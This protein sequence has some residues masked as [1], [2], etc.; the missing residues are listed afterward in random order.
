MVALGSVVFV[1][2]GSRCSQCSRRVRAVYVLYYVGV[3]LIVLFTV[4]AARMASFAVASV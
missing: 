2:V 3:A 4:G 1:F